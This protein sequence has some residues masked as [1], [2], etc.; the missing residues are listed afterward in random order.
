ME[1]Y[2]FMDESG[3]H[4]LKNI[5]PNFPVFVLCGIIISENK[6]YQLIQDFKLLKQKYWG[7]HKVI[8]HSRNIRKCDNE[9][10]ILFDE[11][12]KKSFVSDL[13]NIIS[14]T[15]YT[16]K[17]LI[18]DKKAYLKK[19]GKLK[20]DV[21]ELAL[22]FIIERSVFYLDTISIKIDKL[23]LILEQRGKKEDSKL[24]EHFSKLF[25][26]GT[27]FVSAER[28]RN[29]NFNISFRSKAHDITGLQLSDLIAYPLARYALDKTRFN[30]AYE[31]I[32]SKIYK[33]GERKYGLK[34]F[35]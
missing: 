23:N 35:P 10:Q 1:Y 9:F 21:Y 16:I 31:V 7:N 32:K 13:N 11:K 26:V 5:D 28:I 18:I 24:K 3:D 17:A 8:F 33:K 12:I 4:G 2:L 15:D 34:F 14:K 25:Q 6:Y 20:N 29:Y 30:P 22:S 19:Y 27:Y